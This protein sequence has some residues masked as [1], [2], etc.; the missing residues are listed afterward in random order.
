MHVIPCLTRNRRAS[1]TRDLATYFQIT[2][3]WEKYCGRTLLGPERNLINFI[4]L[5]GDLVKTSASRMDADA[6]WVR[7]TLTYGAQFHSSCWVPKW[8]SGERRQGVCKISG[9]SVSWAPRAGQLRLCTGG[10]AQGFAP[11]VPESQKIL[12]SWSQRLSSW[13]RVQVCLLPGPS[14]FVLLFHCKMGARAAMRKC[15]PQGYLHKV[16]KNGAFTEFY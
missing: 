9:P 13:L 6:C 16:S 1:F 11:S 12:G 4:K 14:S 7:G 8:C 5:W 10:E 3:S 15:G 2:T